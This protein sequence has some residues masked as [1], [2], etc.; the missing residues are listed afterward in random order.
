MV[1]EFV[2]LQW[3]KRSITGQ[4]KAVREY[5]ESY[6]V[7]MLDP[8]S[9]QVAVTGSVGIPHMY[10]VY[11]GADGSTDVHIATLRS[12]TAS[13]H[14]E[15]P[16]FW[17]VICTYSNRTD[18][19]EL[20]ATDPIVRPAEVSWS[21]EEQSFTPQLDCTGSPIVNSARERFDP[22][23]EEDEVVGVLS[24]KR[25]EQSDPFPDIGLAYNDAVNAD[26]FLGSPPGYAKMKLT[27]S[28][29]FENNQYYYDVTYTVKFKNPNKT[30]GWQLRQLDQGYYTRNATTGNTTPIIDASTGQLYQSPTLLDGQGQL[31]KDAV[32][33]IGSTELS[34]AATTMFL[35]TPTPSWAADAQFPITVLIG[36]ELVKLVSYDDGADN[37]AL[38]RA[39]QGTTAAVHAV[40]SAV[41]LTPVYLEFQ[42]HPVLPFSILNI[43]IP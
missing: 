34:A 33:S 39:V 40:G 35:A 3:Q 16:R 29:R 36:S 42:T 6:L 7:K 26:V 21:T 14:E 13:N 31:L 15:D 17:T 9:S 1:A 22:P 18:Q 41:Y 28:R 5:V 11:A 43:H 19:P 27:S 30:Y 32:S 25:V 8:L 23:A 4:E 38:V 37:F 12:I 10:A 2:R 24:Y 20:G